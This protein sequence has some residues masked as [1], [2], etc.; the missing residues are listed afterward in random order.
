MITALGHSQAGLFTNDDGLCKDLREV[1]ET[2]NELS[3]Q[4]PV[5]DYHRK[6]VSPKHCDLTNLGKSGEA[7]ASQAAAFLKAFVEGD[8]K[9]VHLDIAGTSMIGSA[10]TGWGSRLLVEYAR[11][12]AN[13]TH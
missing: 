4:L 9:W 3:W 1:G 2:V 8:T 5:T 13:R 10:A 7:G 6:L 12:V 11:R